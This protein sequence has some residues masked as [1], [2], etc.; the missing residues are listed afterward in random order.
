MDERALKI[1]SLDFE[2]LVPFFK[3][4]YNSFNSDGNYDYIFL[5]QSPG[6]TPV[7][8]DSLIP[9]ISSYIDLIE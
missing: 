4:D 5:T 8:S 6:F 9:V 1:T 2:P 3:I 7:S